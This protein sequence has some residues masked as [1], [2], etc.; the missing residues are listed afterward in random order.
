MHALTPCQCPVESN[1]SFIQNPLSV[2]C[3][4]K[5]CK[6]DDY[7]NSKFNS[8]VLPFLYQPKFNFPNVSEFIIRAWRIIRI[9]ISVCRLCQREL[10][11]TVSPFLY[12]SWIS[13]YPISLYAHFDLVIH[14]FHAWC[15]CRW[16]SMITV[17]ES[18][19]ES[20]KIQ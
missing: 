16:N 18:Y 14:L 8:K 9:F 17:M 6:G 3:I 4:G 10:N 5:L 2:Q 11:S 13:P 7:R 12:V 1:F 19:R 15:R 20:D